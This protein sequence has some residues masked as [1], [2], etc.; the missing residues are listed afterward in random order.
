VLADALRAAFEPSERAK[1]IDE[2]Q[3]IIHE[4]QP[5]LFFRSPESIFIW[6]NQPAK[7]AKVEADRWLQGVV[8]GLDGYH[9]LFSRDNRLWHFLKP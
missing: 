1:I 2:V 4:E 7:G 9:P 5:Y 6:Q 3:A 8:N